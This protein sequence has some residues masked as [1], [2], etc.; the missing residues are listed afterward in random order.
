MLMRDGG[1]AASSRHLLHA[2]LSGDLLLLFVRGG[3]SLRLCG[4]RLQQLGC[5]QLRA[6]DRERRRGGCGGNMAA[7][8][9]RDLRRLSVGA[10]RWLLSRLLTLLLLQPQGLTKI[11]RMRIS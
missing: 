4:L 11:V 2:L 3:Q 10:V 9:R 1:G 5:I 7:I 6:A 8:R